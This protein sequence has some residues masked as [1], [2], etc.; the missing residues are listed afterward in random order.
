M[1]KIF[2]FIQPLWLSLYGQKHWNIFQNIMFHRRK[3]CSF[4]NNTRVSKWWQKCL[5]WVNYPFNFIL[6]LNQTRRNKV[7]SDKG[8][9][10]DS[11]IIISAGQ[12]LI[13]SKISFCLYNMC[14]YCVYL[15][16]IYKYTHVQYIFWKY[17]H[18]L[19]CIYAW[20]HDQLFFFSLLMF[21]CN[22]HSVRLVWHGA[23]SGC[24][25]ALSGLSAG[26]RRGLLQFLLRLVSGAGLFPLVATL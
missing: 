19:T 16:C 14:V 26:Q 1:L 13:A 20:F 9:L 23:H 12:R 6:W 22:S 24:S 17:L 2:L 10:L 21:A 5:F 11:C 15:L 25:V 4:G 3:S 8:H 18:V 7:T